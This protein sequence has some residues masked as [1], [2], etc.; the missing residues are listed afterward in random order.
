LFNGEAGL[1]KYVGQGPFGQS[2]VL[3]H[4]GTEDFLSRSSFERD[5]AAPLAQFDESGA[6]EGPDK[7]LSGDTR[8]FRHLS[9]DFDNCPKGL[10]LGSA[11]LGAA[12]GFE[13]KLNRFS[14]IRACGLDVFTLRSHVE[15]RAARHIPV[16]VFCD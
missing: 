3:W 13:V 7:A 1:A 2:M 14:K 4:D 12:P 5:V 15:F 16:A 9:A 6:L 11:V 10:L 8:Q